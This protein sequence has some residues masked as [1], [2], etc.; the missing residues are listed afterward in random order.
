MIR[1]LHRSR[2]ASAIGAAAP[3]QTGPFG[4]WPE[5]DEDDQDDEQL[6]PELEGVTAHARPHLLG[7]PDAQ[8][9]RTA[10]HEAGHAVVG[11]AAGCTLRSVTVRA[12][13]RRGADGSC[14]LLTAPT[15]TLGIAAIAAG[16]LAQQQADP[17]CDAGPNMAHDLAAILRILDARPE[18]TAGPAFEAAAVAVRVLFPLIE[19]VASALLAPKPLRALS[20]TEIEGALNGAGRAVWE[21]VNYRLGDEIAGGTSPDPW[22]SRYVADGVQMTSNA[23]EKEGHPPWQLR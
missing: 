5:P 7:N 16:G 18:M 19:V 14:R 20:C 11:L 12:N 23:R 8:L 4:T 15:P 21:S 13:R 22:L 3:G 10:I 1:T 6:P 17:Q 9:W 2:G